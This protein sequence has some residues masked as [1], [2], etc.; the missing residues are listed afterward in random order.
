M[1]PRPAPKSSTRLPRARRLAK[2]SSSVRTE[3]RMP[4]RSPYVSPQS[5]TNTAREYPRSP[6]H[7]NSTPTHAS[8]AM[9]EALR[10]VRRSSS[11]V[12]RHSRR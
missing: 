2:Y 7:R 10:S 1:P 9:T 5:S 8:E 6:V 11:P 12:S 4:A 3:T